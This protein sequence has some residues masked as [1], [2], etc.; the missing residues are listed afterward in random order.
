M[1]TRLEVNFPF[2]SDAIK[3]LY[4]DKGDLKLASPKSNYPFDKEEWCRQFEFNSE[5]CSL[6]YKFDHKVI[7]HLAI[8]ENA[9]EIYLCYVIIQNEFRGKG[10]A[11]KMILEAEEFCRLNYHH[12]DIFLNVNKENLRA[13][14]LYKKLGYVSFDDNS[15]NYK[16]VKRLK[17]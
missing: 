8:L 3:H 6:I 15:E 11:E 4:A 16:M 9:E 5:N 13:L 10:L 2:D 1:E 7:G 12:K 14:R 17:R